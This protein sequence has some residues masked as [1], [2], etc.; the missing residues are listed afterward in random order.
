MF[1][2]I[3]IRQKMFCR[4]SLRL[5]FIKHEHFTEE[6]KYD[7]YPNRVI[8]PINHVVKCSRWLYLQKIE[9]YLRNLFIWRCFKC[10]PL[11]FVQHQLNLI[12][13]YCVYQKFSTSWCIIVNLHYKWLEVRGVFDKSECFV[14][15]TFHKCL[16]WMVLIFT[17]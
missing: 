16:D 12:S 17:R 7:L 8:A 1:I 13:M 9:N 4:I 2:Y 6:R 14:C 10:T 3:H 5:D 11:R 15:F